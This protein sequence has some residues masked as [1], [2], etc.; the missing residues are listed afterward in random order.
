M[1]SHTLRRGRVAPREGRSCER[2]N[3]AI[4]NSRRSIKRNDPTRERDNEAPL[5]PS[6]ASH[7]LTSLSRNTALNV[8]RGKGR[9]YDGNNFWSSPEFIRHCALLTAAIS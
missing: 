6:S 9:I 2:K 8:C 4:I 3:R 7:A 5:L 1:F